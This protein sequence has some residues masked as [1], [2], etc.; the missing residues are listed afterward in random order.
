M[1]F[2]A[3][4][5]QVSRQTCSR[6][7]IPVEST[8]TPTSRS[9]I[10]ER[11]PVNDAHVDSFQKHHVLDAL[12]STLCISLNVTNLDRE[13]EWVRHSRMP[14]GS[15]NEDQSPLAQGALAQTSTFSAA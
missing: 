10:L 7:Q 11:R 8:T 15:Q 5:S 9:I 14:A 1:S 12:S 4:S 2:S 6:C 13:P 3:D